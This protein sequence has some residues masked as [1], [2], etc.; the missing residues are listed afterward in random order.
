MTENCVVT[1]TIGDRFA[2][3]SLF[4][5][6]QASIVSG[7]CSLSKHCVREHN[8]DISNPRR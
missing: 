1:L 8:V 5:I 3:S 4:F 6:E 2:D 7:V